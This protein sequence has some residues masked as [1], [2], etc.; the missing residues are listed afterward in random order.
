MTGPPGVTAAPPRLLRSLDDVGVAVLF[1]KNE[2]IPH[3]DR[4]YFA[5]FDRTQDSAV[6]DPSPFSALGWI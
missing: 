2:P 5:Q 6:R 1:G 4:R 3:R